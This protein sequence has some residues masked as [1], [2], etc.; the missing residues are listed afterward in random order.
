MVAQLSYVQITSQREHRN[1]HQEATKQHR[2][3]H[4][5]VIPVGVADSPPNADPLL[6]VADV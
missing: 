3:P 5:R 4:R 1:Y 2:D 6:P